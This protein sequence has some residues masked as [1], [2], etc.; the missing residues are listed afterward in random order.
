MKFRSRIIAA[1]IL[2]GLIALPNLI[3]AH[4]ALVSAV[5]TNTEPSKTE[6]TQIELKFNTSIEPFS[7]MK[8]KDDAGNAYSLKKTSTDGKLLTGTLEE[9]L[10]NGKYSVDWHIIGADGHAIKGSY[11]F[12][13][14]IPEP[15]PTEIASP[16]AS[17]TQGQA[18]SEPII[19]DA[20]KISPSETPTPAETPIST[21]TASNTES[22]QDSSL[23]TNN[24]ISNIVLIA[25]A[26][27]LIIAILFIFFKKKNK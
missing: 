27:F 4:S 14:S 26:S 25:A 2:L 19:S 6:V 8:V 23:K 11:S 5:P 15:I 18:T 7:N 22:E 10:K 12:A 1:I 24:L 20:P 13:V 9:P 16:S 21:E 17:E 3:Y